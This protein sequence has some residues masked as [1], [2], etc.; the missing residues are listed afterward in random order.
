MP[1]GKRFVKW[2]SDIG[3]VAFDHDRQETTI[4]EM[5]A[6]NVTITAV[7][8]DIDYTV[9]GKSPQGKHPRAKSLTSGLAK[10][11]A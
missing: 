4:F 11:T 2:T 7:F 3:T 1:T 6:N 9:T 5:P 8:E 10:R